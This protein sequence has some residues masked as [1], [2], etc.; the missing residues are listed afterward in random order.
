MGLFSQTEWESIRR[1]VEQEIIEARKGS[2]TLWLDI[3]AI[4]HVQQASGRFIYRLLLSQPTRLEPEQ[5][6]TFT[7]RGKEKIRATVVA[8]SDNELVVDCEGP[9]PDDARLQQVELDP[10]FIYEALLDFLAAKQ[11]KPGT[12]ASH[13]RDRN[14]PAAQAR[15]TQPSL[16]GLNEHQ[17]EAIAAMRVDP[18]HVLWGPPGTGKT[19][20]LGAAIAGWMRE[21]KSVLVV[22]TSNAAVDVAVKSLLTR[23]RPQEKRGVLRLGTSTDQEVA[24]LTLGSKYAER[25]PH[26]SAEVAQAQGRMRQVSEIVATKLNRPDELQRL[27]EEKRK[28]EP[29]VAR[30]N[31]E[32]AAAAGS[33]AAEAKVFACTLAKMVLDREVRNRT[34]DVVVVDEASMVSMLYALAAATLAGSHLVYAG[35]PKQLPP[36]V[37]SETSDAERWFGTNVFSWL[38]VSES[39]LAD[40]ARLPMTLLRT[41]YRMTERI[42]GIVSRLSYRD[43]L[44]HG[45]AQKG[46]RVMLVDVP[47]PWQTKL[48]SVRERSYY[49]PA[50]IPLLHAMIGSLGGA[51][52]EML[53]LAPFR[54]QQSLL[55]AVA[56]D[57]KTKHPEWDIRSSTIHR[58]QGSER[59]TVIVDLTTHAPTDLSSFFEDDT[60]DLLFNVAIS[61]AAD[62]LVVIGSRDMIRAVAR[63]RPFWERVER[64]FGGEDS[65]F[66]GADEVLEEAERIESLRHML[67]RPV[68]KAMPAICCCQGESPSEDE[69]VVLGEVT[70]TR[71]LLVAKDTSAVDGRFIMR[72]PTA[73]CSPLFA[74]HG[75]VAIPF[76]GSWLVAESPGASRV[77]WRIGFSHLAE[78]EVNPNEARRFFCPRCVPGNLLLRRTAT[79]W[80]LVCSE[81][82]QHCAYSRHLS[83]EDA[84][85]KVRLQGMTCPDGHPLTARTSAKGIFLGCE[86]YPRCEFTSNLG[87][88]V[89]V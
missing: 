53:L 29:V 6:I 42:G 25:Q 21:G 58:S 85:A 70:A 12:L 78:E 35:D 74:A 20:T 52:K 46:V 84:K 16:D 30:F 60:G 75:H 14:L 88:L 37:Q 54:A 64:E 55:S 40:S 11:E 13:L 26:K 89:G 63:H 3:D 62:H 73:S 59:H 41:Q 77:L 7:S 68:N 23:L 43:R 50:T 22:S 86:N 66:Y 39:W 48:W 87:L 76:D 38:G 27:F 10:S 45:R 69:L 80:M 9:L 5:T 44:I 8:S 72:T 82:P 79:G 15:T 4:E 61:R 18:L 71:K 49:Q 57:L 56:F 33:L 28:L 65:D 17:C 1:A 34:F 32:V 36:I 67:R 31:E 19:H 81:S 2:Q 24:A 47:P 51:K 83:L